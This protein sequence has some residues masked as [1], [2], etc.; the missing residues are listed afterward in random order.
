MVV[1]IGCAALAAVYDQIFD[2]PGP[3]VH[4]NLRFLRE[5]LR[6]A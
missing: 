3:R 6:G 4:R 1:S 2:D 5:P